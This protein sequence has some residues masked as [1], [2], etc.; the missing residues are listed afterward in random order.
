M[1]PVAPNVSNGWH[2]TP[3]TT[4]IAVDLDR[5]LIYSRRWFS[6]TDRDTAWCVERRDGREVSFMTPAAM[7]ALEQLAAGPGQIV[8]PATTRALAHYQRIALPGGP[9][10][11]AVTSNG[12][13]ILVD[14]QPDPTW[15]ATV[16]ATL[17]AESV[18]LEVLRTALH[19]A[20]SAAAWV[21]RF[22]VVD[23]L[24]CY[25]VIDESAMP[26]DFI[27]LWKDWCEP[28]GWKVVRQDRKIYTLP[29][30]L[31]KSHAVEEV[32]KRLTTRGELIADAPVL[33]A[34]DGALD[35][36]LLAAANAAI[37]PS[38]GELHN[39][40]WRTAKTVVATAF[41]AKAAE[42]ILTW[43]RLRAEAGRGEG[44]SV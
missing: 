36:A 28:R 20:I 11:Y 9:Y 18:P 10:R 12:G 41:G 15:T 23:G 19:T 44:T 24:F 32:R 39:T 35:T 1:I 2:S 3:A 17:R 8:V 16:A 31:C 26:Q 25:V 6:D 7:A 43:C 30:S 40:G 5:T 27:E 38:H 42:Q 21:H 34:G 14:G 29:R 37:R 22:V 4:L 33:A 13:T